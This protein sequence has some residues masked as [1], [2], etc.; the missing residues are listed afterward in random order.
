MEKCVHDELCGGCIYQ[1]VPY[2]EQLKTKEEQV[3]GY[4]LENGIKAEVFEKI[5]GAP[6][7]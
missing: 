7:L 2:E 4:M 5:E 3:K 6:S 1:G